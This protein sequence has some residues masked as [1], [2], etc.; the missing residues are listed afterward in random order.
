MVVREIEIEGKVAFRERMETALLMRRRRLISWPGSLGSGGSL[1]MFNEWICAKW[2]L[3][4]RGEP[5][6]SDVK[7]VDVGG[8]F[9]KLIVHSD[10]G[11]HFW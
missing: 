3:I 1:L 4:L 5:A 6:V 2:V 7:C 8:L 10:G 9:N 11:I